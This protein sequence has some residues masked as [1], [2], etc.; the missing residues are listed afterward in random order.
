MALMMPRFIS[1][2]GSPPGELKV[3]NS[4]KDCPLAKDWIVLH[5]LDL[6]NHTSQ[7][8]GEAD[9]VIIIP[10]LGTLVLEVKSH[11]YIKY[12]HGNWWLGNNAQPETRGPFKQASNAMHSIRKY[13]ANYSAELGNTFFTSAVCFS[14]A[15]FSQKS[16]EWHNW[17]II[18][19]ELFERQEIGLTVSN[20]LKRLS[21]SLN[22]KIFVEEVQTLKPANSWLKFS[23]TLQKPFQV[24]RQ[25]VK[26]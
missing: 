10:A 1:S 14:D 26:N 7:I 3:F 23:D 18:D 17:Q 25:F 16:P 24:Q 6:A 4:L 13:V 21:N 9:F 11:K 19:K 2:A 15:N 12:E 5:S 8:S 20:I 22:P